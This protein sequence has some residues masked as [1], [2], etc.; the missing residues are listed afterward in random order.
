MLKLATVMAASGLMLSTALAQSSPPATNMNQTPPAGAQSTP[1]PGPRANTT[2][3]SGQAI[4]AQKPDQ[5]LAS[6]FKGTDVLGPDDQKVGDVNDI[7]FDK[8]GKIEAYIV[9][10]GGFLGMGA[11]EIALPPNSFQLVAGK[12]NDPNEMK[13]K[14]SMTKDQLQSAAN[15][16]KYNPPRTTTG[17]GAPATRP[18]GA[19]APVR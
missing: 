11:K 8:D 12:D 16:E 19:P 3:T 2:A 5:M 4:T 17:S 7:L 13:L 15:F 18:A 6:K 14:I 10:V 1:A 9:S